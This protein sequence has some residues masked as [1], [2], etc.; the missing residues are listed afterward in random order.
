M[1]IDNYTF[2]SPAKKKKIHTYNSALTLSGSV[3]LWVKPISIENT[4]R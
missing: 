2:E 4:S 1:L 3:H